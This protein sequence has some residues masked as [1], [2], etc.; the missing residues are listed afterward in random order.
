LLIIPGIRIP[1]EGLLKDTG[2]ESK[3]LRKVRKID[4]AI[5]YNTRNYKGVCVKI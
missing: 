3:V 5:L 4:L 1:E 2:K